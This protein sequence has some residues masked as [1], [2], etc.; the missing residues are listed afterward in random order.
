[1]SNRVLLVA[2]ALACVAAIAPPPQP[3]DVVLR[4]PRVPR[5][6]GGGKLWLSWDYPAG[7]S[8]IVFEVWKGRQT[9]GPWMLMT[10]CVDRAVE[11]GP[12]Y[13]HVRARDTVMDLVSEAN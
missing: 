11:V 6:A 9:S 7:V 1:M 8:N 10:N 4:R 12:G 3:K 13:Y 2:V 5:A